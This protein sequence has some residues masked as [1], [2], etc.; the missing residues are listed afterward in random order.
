MAASCRA[1]CNVR[2]YFNPLGLVRSQ[3]GALGPIGVRLLDS[4]THRPGRGVPPGKT[5]SQGGYRRS[6]GTGSGGSGS[7]GPGVFGRGAGVR[8]SVRVMGC[9]VLLGAGLGTYQTV[10]NSVQTHLA[11]EDTKVTHIYQS[12]HLLFVSS[13]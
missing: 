6:Y 4:E 1:L 8:V 2:S 13:F 5:S 9:A 10:K 3:Y 11:A 7:S 12:L